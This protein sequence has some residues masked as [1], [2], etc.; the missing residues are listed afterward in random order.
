MNIVVPYYYQ[1]ADVTSKE[2]Q[3][4]AC[5]IVCL[6][7][8]LESRRIEAPSL[9]EMIVHGLAIGAYGESGWKHDGLIALALKYEAKLTRAEWRQSDTR[10]SE[11]LNE[12]GIQFLISELRAERAVIVSA[13]K[14][15]QEPKKFHM[16]VLVGLEEKEGKVTGFYYHDSEA[17]GRD[18]GKNLFVPL[19]IFRTKWRRMAIF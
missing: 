11:E 19:E 4:R 17:Q 1:F 12:E 8:L 10:T 2:W 16:V 3:P 9:D 7:I 13:I 5:G 6:K 14:K 15:F 18:E